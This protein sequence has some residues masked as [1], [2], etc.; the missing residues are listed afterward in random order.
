MRLT[1][2]ELEQF[3]IEIFEDIEYE[4]ILGTKLEE[5]E[6]PNQVV[7]YQRLIDS[8]YKINKHLPNLAREQGINQLLRVD[9]P[10]I[11]LQNLYVHNLL[12]K[13]VTITYFE[14]GTD[15]SD[16]VKLID[17][18]NPEN[19]DFLV[20]N[21]F[22]VVEGL[23]HQKR[24][25]RPDLV[26][27]VNGLPLV[28]IEL[29]NPADENTDIEYAYNQIQTYKQD[30]PSL[31]RY[32]EILVVSD[33]LEA[34]V[35]S[36]SANF[37]RFIPWRTIDGDTEASPSEWQIEILIRGLLQ[38]AR[39]LDYIRFFITFEDDG[40]ELIK[41]SAAYHQFHAVNTAV[42][43]TVKATGETGDKKI[44][45]VWHTQGSGKSLTM[46]FYAGKIIQNLDNPT[47]LVITDR[48]DLDG[49]LFNTFALSKDLLRQEPK[50]A[51]DRLEIRELLK[52]TGG[53]VIFSTIQKFLP[54]ENETEYPILTD[55]KNVIVIA[56]EAHRSQYSFQ[57]SAKVT[58]DDDEKIEDIAIKEGF[59]AHIRKA[60]PNASFIGFT[61]TPIDLVDRNTIHVFGNYL[62]IYD[63]SQAIKD[64]TTVPI[65]YESRLAK[66]KLNEKLKPEEIDEEFEEITE[67]E[68]LYVK[69]KLKSKWSRV[70]EIVG[71]EDRLTELADDIVNHFENRYD[72]IKGKA[73]IVCMTRDICVRLYDKIVDL[74]P[75]WHSDDPN[76][77][78]IKVIM[79]GS[80]SDEP[81][82]QKHEKTKRVKKQ[83]EKRMKDP[84][85]TLKIVIVRDM[86]LTG[87]DVPSLHTMY[88]DK[89]MQGHSLMQ[90]IARV[91]RVWNNKPAGLIV[92]YIGIGYFLKQALSKYSDPT[93]GQVGIDQEEAVQLM[94]SWL[95]VCREIFY[96]F[97]YTAF[98]EGSVTERL[99]V[100]PNAIEF[101]LQLEGGQG[102]NRFLDGLASLNN[103]FSLA[104]PHPKAIEIREEVAFFQAV[105]TG[106]IK[107][108]VT[109]IGR[110]RK[111]D[112]DYA[113]RQL[114]SRAVVSDEV[115]DIFEA[116]GFDKPDISILS[117]EFLDE[118]KEMPQK[119][120]A[121]EMMHKLLNDEI[122]SRQ[123]KNVTESRSFAELLQNAINK[124]Q[125]RTIEA[126]AI[127]E[128][129]IRLAR[130]IR[131]AKSKGEE[132]GLSDD[133]VAFYDA[134]ATNE[135]AVREMPDETLKQISRELV[136]EVRKS[137]SIDFTKRSSVQAQM[138]RSIKRLLRKYKYPPDQQENAV[139]IIMEQAM[140]FGEEWATMNIELAGTMAESAVSDYQKKVSELEETVQEMKGV[141]E[142]LMSTIHSFSFN[143][144]QTQSKMKDELLEAI[145]EENV[146]KIEELTSSIVNRFV[147][148]FHKIAESDENKY[149]MEKIEE[150]VVFD[151]GEEMWEQFTEASRKEILLSDLL[152]LKQINPEMAILSICKVI[153]RELLDLIFIP[154]KE[155]YQ[156][157][158]LLENPL[159]LRDV[160]KYHQINYVS[161]WNYV[162]RDR[163]LTLGN[164]GRIMRSLNSLKRNTVLKHLEIFYELLNFI[165]SKYLGSTDKLIQLIASV[166]DKQFESISI[167]ELRNKAAHPPDSGISIDILNWETYRDLNEFAI[168]RQKGLI[169]FLI[170]KSR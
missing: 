157:E 56:D 126:S 5:R 123:K 38:P 125:N 3:C 170:A 28:V 33:G 129:M 121:V 166:E 96:G 27:F 21:Q 17:F 48:N 89:P 41:K 140:L 69:E 90:A 93:R 53:G 153:E 133:E 54:S 124:Y 116:V 20:V 6:S 25:R 139:K 120:L 4:Y 130:D 15:K 60:L 32:N 49:Q 113:I 59:A 74:R 155:K 106:I 16:I 45:I 52:T 55:R 83:I 37:E 119:N 141:Q 19:N 161:L 58:Y 18:K 84:D 169:P 71:D 101:I 68:E 151:L 43:N 36:L 135:S 26:V 134:I 149:G 105:R 148:D 31:F 138:R 40:S 24:N 11:L 44:G 8:I 85:D 147:Q 82:L 104:I 112:I 122:K 163:Y 73:I 57:K 9:T 103:A 127:I 65:Y 108:T 72:V 109:K 143:I 131:K 67:D 86:W 92:D 39:L 94:L 10:D 50:Q 61:G 156:D 100:L 117:N 30:I 162:Y 167:V 22:T 99:R 81:Y 70:A 35:G 12:V 98:F 164:F 107:T 23:R 64:R 115:I 14:D 76:D 110:K 63:I 165:H 51:R 159:E 7:L 146:T 154:F 79:S 152:F 168:D 2:E 97:D 91:N 77:G 87:F 46:L 88:I 78:V 34:Q 29:K 75:E 62:S 150:K 158:N 114:V 13:G 42:E 80:A 102:K 145:K 144:D 111:R 132:L 136:N 95:E 160:A 137:A 118:I 66:L 128:E 142:Q 1:E 47:I